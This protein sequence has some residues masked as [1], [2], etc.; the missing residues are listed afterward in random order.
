[1]K[2][3]ISAFDQSLTAS[4]G[5]LT[6]SRL[7]KAGFDRRDFYIYLLTPGFS[8]SY[9]Q[10][11]LGVSDL[12]LRKYI[13]LAQR[14]AALDPTIQNDVM[15]NIA[16]ITPADGLQMALIRGRC[17]LPHWS[18]LA[19]CQAYSGTDNLCEVARMFMC[20]PSAAR[21]AVKLTGRAFDTLSG[22][23]RS[24][25][26]QSLPSGRWL[27]GQCGRTHFTSNKSR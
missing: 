1:M 12:T 18:R 10:H 16:S 20:S 26:S 2:H 5:S 15:I 14:A 21:S 27:P 19:I 13:R 25:S 11:V 8:F 9:H 17:H 23:R 3:D 7:I 4:R 24:S 22:K 6:I